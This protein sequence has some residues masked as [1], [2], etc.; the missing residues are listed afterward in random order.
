M[1]TFA[2]FGVNCADSVKVYFH[3]GQYR[4]EPGLNENRLA[5]DGFIE[6][7]R[8]AVDS[9]DIDCII[10]HGYTSPDGTVR[11]NERLARERCATIADYIVAKAGVS[12]DL[13]KEV[14]EGIG[15]DEL[16]RLVAVTPDVPSRDAILNILDNTPVWVQ[17]EQGKIVDG[18]KKQLMDLRGGRPYKWMLANL[19]P[20]LRN[21]VGVMLY[22]KE[23]P[24]SDAVPAEETKTIDASEISAQPESPV[25]EGSST[26][27][28]PQV[29]PADSDAVGVTY[30]R[31]HFALKTNILYDAALMPDLE[32][33][34]L[35]NDRWGVSLEGDV[36]W[37]KFDDEKIYRLAIV[38]PEVRYYVKPLAPFHG[39]Y[40]GALVGGGLYQLQHG[41]EGYRGEGAMGGVSGGYMFPITRNLS[42]DAEIGVGYLYSRYKVY[43]NRDGHKLYMRTKSLNYFGPIKV[44]FSIAWRFDILTKST[45]P[46]STL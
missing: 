46:N 43:E 9:G 41:R 32:L 28:E 21:V 34:W 36:A 19:F 39:L 29:T 22:L 27:V 12:A 4:F 15:W 45:K 26:V 44:K 25:N 16:R 8:G 35:V 2:S 24:E 6:K 37:W 7:V 30:K 42:F 17:N 38:S 14:P 20:Q 11:T 18:R 10:V 13:I 31:H 23:K 33:E 40:V 1:I 3:V 5:M